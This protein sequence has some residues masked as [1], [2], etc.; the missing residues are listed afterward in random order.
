MGSEPV[1]D[2]LG[3]SLFRAL[4]GNEQPPNR[5][6]EQAIAFDVLIRT[7]TNQF[8]EW[9]PRG[10]WLCGSPRAGGFCL[11]VPDSHSEEDYPID[12]AWIVASPSP[13]ASAFSR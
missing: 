1:L 11:R 9:L 2:R 8:R 12:L 7:L 4:P 3:R 10:W 6:R 5:V 13:P